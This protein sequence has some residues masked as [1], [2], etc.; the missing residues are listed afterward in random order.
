VNSCVNKLIIAM[1]G[2]RYMRTAAVLRKRFIELKGKLV[3]P[4]NLLTA[5]DLTSRASLRQ[6]AS[7]NRE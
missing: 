5:N 1:N 6:R 2:F 4:G 7:G 3:S